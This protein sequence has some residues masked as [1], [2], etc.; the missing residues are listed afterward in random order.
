MNPKVVDEPAYRDRRY[1][2]RDRLHAG[3]LLANKLRSRLSDI[4]VQLL[5]IPAGGVPVGCVVAESLGVRFD[6]AIVRKVQIPWN[7]EAG[8]G[9]VAWDGTVI[10]NGPLIARLGL[11][12]ELVRRC[13]SL[14][15]ETVRYRLD[16]FRGNRSF[17][18]LKDQTVV[19]VDDGLASGF[20]MLTAMEAVKKQGPKKV[21]V[22][23]P[24]ASTGAIDLVTPNVDE[25]IC[26]N[27]R[28]GPVFAVAD[29]YQEWHDLS[30][31]EVME[32]LGK[33]VSIGDFL[34]EER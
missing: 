30:D 31:E 10:L 8:F 16:K 33:F 2:F 22:A 26:L 14:T 15:R 3:G 1:V 34:H 4:D 7:P 6:V 24:T 27:I 17:P 23:V 21:V 25:L 32:F 20:T 29:A 11:S 5:A 9:A 18:Q 19:L 28:G 13:V 12:T